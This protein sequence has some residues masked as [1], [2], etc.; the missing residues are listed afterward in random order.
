[1]NKETVKALASRITHAEVKIDSWTRELLDSSIQLFE[2]VYDHALRQDQSAF[3]GATL[4]AATQAFC[5]FILERGRALTAVVCS[6]R[7]PGK[8]LPEARPICADGGVLC[9]GPDPPHGLL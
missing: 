9:L 2:A 7:R 3:Q 5:T 1:M 4:P 6:A 8:G